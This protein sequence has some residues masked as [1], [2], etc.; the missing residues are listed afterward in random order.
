MLACI[1]ACVWY[2]CVCAF[3]YA[4]ITCT[5]GEFMHVCADMCVHVMWACILCM[6]VCVCMWL[7]GLVMF[8]GMWARAHI[9]CHCRGDRHVF[10]SLRSSLCLPFL[11]HSEAE[12]TLAAS[13][14]HSQ[15]NPEAGGRGGMGRCSSTGFS[16]HQHHLPG[17]HGRSL[18]CVHV[19]VV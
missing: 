17:P 6:H 9:H 3:V 18:V 7:E 15:L 4:C 5:W 11:L 12:L 16:G 2:A 19:Q 8:P 1:C 10:S 13:S 14:M